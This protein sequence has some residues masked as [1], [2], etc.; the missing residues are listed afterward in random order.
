[1]KNDDLD[2]LVYFHAHGVR[3][4]YWK[5]DELQRLCPGLRLNYWPLNANEVSKIKAG[6]LEECPSN[7]Q[8]YVPKGLN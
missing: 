8:Y 1:M 5:H 7:A 2:R 4:N 6:R 3:N